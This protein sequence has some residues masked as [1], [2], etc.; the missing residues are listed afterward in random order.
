LGK[1]VSRL[2]DI[3]ENYRNIHIIIYDDFKSDTHKTYCTVLNFLSLPYD[4][5]KD[6]PVF[7]SNKI[8]CRSMTAY[9]A[10][11]LTQLYRFLRIKLN[12]TMFLNNPIV[13]SLRSVFLKFYRKHCVE[14]AKRETPSEVF[15]QEL[16]HYFHGDVMLL[17]K[18]LNRDLSDW[19]T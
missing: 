13:D 5:R 11:R 8:L 4:G 10:S 15:I 6:F 9:I 7:N 12:R 14:V 2:F 16:K 19:V 3:V 17:S 1:Q 18:L